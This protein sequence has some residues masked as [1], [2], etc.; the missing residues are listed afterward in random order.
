LE[1]VGIGFAP[2]LSLLVVLQY[3]GKLPP[4]RFIPLLF[5][6]PATTLVMVATNDMHH[7]FY[8]DIHFRENAPLPL[9]DVSIG[10]W[11]IVQGCFT[12]GSMLAA[13]VLLL[14]RWRQTNAAFRPQLA[15][16][17]VGQ[18]LPIVTAFLYLVGLTPYGMDIVPMV[19]CVTSALYIWAMVRSHLLT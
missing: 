17:I 13:L 10:Q 7:L 18:I 9:V 6:I 12:F 8:K 5:V 16:L 4:R 11:Y 19:L 3:I 14:S 15:T 2:P 1:Y